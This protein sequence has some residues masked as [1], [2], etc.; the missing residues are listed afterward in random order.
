MQG[1]QP[2]YLH[3][4]HMK[5]VSNMARHPRTALCRKVKIVSGYRG[6]WYGGRGGE[7][8]CSSHGMDALWYV[9]L[10]GYGVEA[11]ERIAIR[12]WDREEVWECEV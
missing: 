12:I 1:N 10:V 3:T 2:R 11:N 8:R 4:S 6:K 9:V 7:G 5:R